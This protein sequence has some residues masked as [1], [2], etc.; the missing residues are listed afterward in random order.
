MRGFSNN[1]RWFEGLNLNFICEHGLFIKRRGKDWEA[2]AFMSSEIK[3]KIKS[4][5]EVYVDRLPR[6]FIEEKEY[7]IVFHYRN[8][9]PEQANLRVAELVDELLGFTGTSEFPSAWTNVPCT[10]TFKVSPAE[11]LGTP[12][13]NL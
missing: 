7:S 5:M 2:T 13:S 12:Q 4:I 1:L 3:N 10:L 11:G 8:A 6:S 9:D